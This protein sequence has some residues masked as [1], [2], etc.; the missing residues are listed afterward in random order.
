MKLGLVGLPGAGKTTLFMA[1]TGQEVD[2]SS[3]GGKEILVQGVVP[4]PDARLDWL[5]SQFPGR[6]KTA[7]QVTYVDFHG[8]GSGRDDKKSYV[9]A[10]LN[11]AR[12]MDAFVIVLRNF[13]NPA[14]PPPDPC[15]DLEELTQEFVLADLVTVEKRLEKIGQEKKKGRRIPERELE[16]LE[17]CRDVLNGEE[18]L[19]K[20]PELA[21]A[22]ELRGF[23]FLSGKPVLVVVNNDD[24][25]PEVPPG[26]YGDVEPVAVRA[27]LE[28]ELNRL[29]PDESEV[30]REEYG[31]E[32][33]ACDLV[34]SRSFSV[35]RLVTFY[36]VGDDEIRAWTVQ[37]GTTA[38]K[39]A[40][41]IHSDMER[42]FIRAE[43]INFEDLK[44]VGTFASARKEGLMRLEG[45]DY[46]VKDGDILHIR[47]SAG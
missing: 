19:R 25:D 15:R 38:L 10:L 2:R 17:K 20:Y 6:K 34:I 39:A 3:G 32:S 1:L 42:G 46:I 41:T 8:L 22:H 29:N 36:T 37:E 40:G 11:Y 23:T 35:L 24:E 27:R 4:V 16:L 5:V 26:N 21:G 14:F 18:P 31:L 12:P 43:V 7:V 44:K 13:A 30:F 9:S 28:L 47:F 45:R 33:R